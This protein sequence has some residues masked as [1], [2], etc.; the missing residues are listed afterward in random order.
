MLGVVVVGDVHKERWVLGLLR[1]DE[2]PLRR[3]WPTLLLLLE[4]LERVLFI[5]MKTTSCP[6]FSL[7]GIYMPVFSVFFVCL[8]FP[9]STL[10]LLLSQVKIRWK[11]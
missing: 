4:G 11:V 8:L 10:F 7:S 6:N 1:E 2:A 9:F 3:V 5:C